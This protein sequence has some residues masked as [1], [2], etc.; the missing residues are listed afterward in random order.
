MEEHLS[1]ETRIRVRYNECDSSGFAF[2]GNFFVWMQD[3]AGDLFEA[4]GVDIVELAMSGHT[5]MAIHME[6]D[7]KHPT[8]YRDEIVV[9]AFVSEL[10]TSSLH[11]QYDITKDDKLLAV[12]RTV[13]VYVDIEQKKKIPMPDDLREKLLLVKP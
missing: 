8:R 12:G 10:G 7:F 1:S 9:R 3:G 2:N 4:G 13:H 11:I 5:F 6:C